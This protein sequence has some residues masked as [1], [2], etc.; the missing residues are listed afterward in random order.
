MERA[1]AREPRV[2]RTPPPIAIVTSLAESGV[3]LE[4]QFCTSE[5]EPDPLQV[6]SGIC[7]E[8]MRAFH[9]EGVETALPSPDARTQAS[10]EGK[11]PPASSAA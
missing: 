9:D 5:A 11:L 1:A 4:L 6:K 8:I 7:L 10:A 3:T 2:L